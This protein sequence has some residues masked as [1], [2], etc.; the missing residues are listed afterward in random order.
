MVFSMYFLEW[1][2]CVYI[3]QTSLK[4]VLNGP[5]ERKVSIG[6]GS[7]L[8]SND[9][10]T[11][12]VN[13]DDQFCWHIYVSLIWW[14]Y[15]NNKWY[16]GCLASLPCP[17]ESNLFRHCSFESSTMANISCFIAPVVIAAVGKKLPSQLLVSDMS[18]SQ[19]ICKHFVIVVVCNCFSLSI[20][21]YITSLKLGQ[22]CDCPST[23]E[24]ILQ[25]MGK[26]IIWI[27]LIM[28]PQQY[29]AQGNVNVFKCNGTIPH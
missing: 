8:L 17:I 19:E 4:L 5:V 10:W 13:N 2:L 3:I 28:L 14:Y 25:N 18:T 24:E 1:H 27:Q 21:F 12:I 23:S 16:I 20:S 29:K 6:S 7:G 11:F 22:P 9:Q 15:F 26:G